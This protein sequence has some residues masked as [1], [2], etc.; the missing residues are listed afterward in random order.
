MHVRIFVFPPEIR[1]EYPPPLLKY[2]AFPPI[3]GMFYY[4]PAE[5]DYEYRDGNAPLKG[6][7][8]KGR[9]ESGRIFSCRGRY[10]NIFSPPKRPAGRYF[11]GRFLGIFPNRPGRFFV[12]FVF[13]FQ[14]KKKTGGTF[15]SMGD[16][17]FDQQI[18]RGTQPVIETLRIN[19]DIGKKRERL[20]KNIIF[21]YF[22]FVI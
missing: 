7:N 21:R 9:I 18:C 10:T 17:V 22:Y 8:T 19:Q 1:G 4:P 2:L 20:E 6:R 15:G 11:P 3:W 5:R 14:G 13:C 16:A 12:V